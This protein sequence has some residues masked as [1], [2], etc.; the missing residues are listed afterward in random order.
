MLNQRCC[1][2]GPFTV[3]MEAG[4]LPPLQPGQVLARTC[5]SLISP[6][7]E[8]AMYTHSHVGF[9]DPNNKFA[10]YPFYPGYAGVGEV[11]AA[12]EGASFGPGD[13]LFYR[14]P[15]QQYTVLTPERDNVQPAPTSIPATW[16]PFARMAQA[17]RRRISM[18]RV[19]FPQCRGEDHTPPTRWPAPCPAGAR[20]WR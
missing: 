5:Y 3:V 10:K 13:R 19:G 17:P 8:L 16:V 4:D 9:S 6:G 11:V 2:S 18:R 7:T 1:I 14:S 20:R 12:G 15:H